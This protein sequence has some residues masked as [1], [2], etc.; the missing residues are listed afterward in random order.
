[1]CI[2]V[3]HSLSDCFSMPYGIRMRNNHPVLCYRLMLISYVYFLNIT[4]CVNVFNC[5]MESLMS[6]IIIT[7]C[8]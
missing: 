8:E 3:F 1:M 5:H 2:F 4:L 6:K 7:F